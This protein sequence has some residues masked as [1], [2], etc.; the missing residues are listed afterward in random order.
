MVSGRD[1]SATACV[2]RLGSAACV[3]VCRS[4]IPSTTFSLL[5]VKIDLTS[6]GL[7]VAGLSFRQLGGSSGTGAHG[8]STWC[9]CC[10]HTSIVCG[11]MFIRDVFGML[12]T[13]FEFDVPLLRPDRSW[14]LTCFCS[15]LRSTRAHMGPDILHDRLKVGICVCRHTP[16]VT[17][18][19]LGRV[20]VG[21]SC[22][23]DMQDTP[24]LP[25]HRAATCRCE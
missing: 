22:I 13:V 9:K 25:R 23:V 17:V 19:F 8:I 1:W 21:C 3:E 20:R 5:Y 10:R 2:P 18:A 11:T 7:P 6:V 15:M 12:C 4:M 14:R 16:R 24:S